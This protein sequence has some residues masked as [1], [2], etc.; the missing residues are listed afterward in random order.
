MSNGTTGEVVQHHPRPVRH[1]HVRSTMTSLSHQ[2]P[3]LPIAERL[4]SFYW[5]SGTDCVCVAALTQALRSS[6]GRSF[7]SAWI[8]L[9]VWRIF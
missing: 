5:D 4:P 3:G 8:G 6:R 1:I 9:N 2:R 7:N